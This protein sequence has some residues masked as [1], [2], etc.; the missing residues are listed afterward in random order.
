MRQVREQ[1]IGGLEVRRYVFRHAYWY[2]YMIS[3]W[4]WELLRFMGDSRIPIG[5]SMEVGGSQY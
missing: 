3:L 5:P 4:G 1:K 2:W